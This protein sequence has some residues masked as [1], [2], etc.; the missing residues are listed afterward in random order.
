[1]RSE[2]TIGQPEAGL[3]L[4]VAGGGTG[5]HIS[6]AIAVVQELQHRRPIDVLWIGSG[7][8]FERSA[9]ALL[10]AE[11]RTVRTGKLRRYLSL[12]TPL[13]AV[14]IPVGIGQAWSILGG[15][16]PDVVLSTGG[17]VSVPTVIAARLRRI[18]ALT[19]E[20][21]AHIG[22]ATKIN[23]RFVDTVALSFDR[24]RSFINSPSSRILVTGNPV[25]PAVVGGNRDDALRR[26]D[27]NG[28]LPLVYITGGMQGARALNQVVGDALPKLLGY[29]ECV[30]QCGPASIH[31][32]AAQ[33][34]EKASELPAE[35]RARYRIVET[36]GDELGDL[37]AASSLV[38]GR[39]GAGTIN[40]LGALGI[41]SIL[42]PLPGAE[43]QRQNALQLATAGGAIVVSQD[44]LTASW[45]AEEIRELVSH[46]ERLQAM[47]SAARSQAHPDAAAAIADELLRL[48]RRGF[49]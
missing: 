14:R 25:R 44:E 28:E 23:A 46:P 12:E 43:E 41:P 32:D 39:S 15:W 16:R 27:L 38:V 34:R 7:H 48:A 8:E 11:Y 22:L 36:V 26:F 19:H 21:T 37:Y 2:S 35:Y 1:M 40:E 42:V 17:F 24:S 6:P 33:L 49:A 30:H 29:V 18:P 13:D 10:G 3:R 31:D 4:V 47:A 5:G 20:Q 45:L 9:A